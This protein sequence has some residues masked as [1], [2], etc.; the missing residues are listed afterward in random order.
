MHCV[1]A[2]LSTGGVQVVAESTLLQDKAIARAVSSILARSESQQDITVLVRTYVDCGVLPELLNQNAQILH[3]R[4]GT[5]K[6]HVFLVLGDA[7]DREPASTH[8]YVDLRLL[9]S[10][11]LLT[12]SDQ[13]LSTRCIVVFRDFLNTIQNRLLDMATDPD[14]DYP[15]NAIEKVDELS[16]AINEATVAVSARQVSTETTST[17]RDGLS[18]GVKMSTTGM[19][20]QLA[21]D[22]RQDNTSRRAQ[23]YEE[24]IHQTV[25]FASVA[26]RLDD[27]LTALGIDHFYLLVDEWASLPRDIQ[28]YVAEFLRRTVLPSARM[29]LKI[30]ALEYRSRFSIALANNNLVGF[31][32]G[33]DIAAN[34]NLDDYFVHDRTPSRVEGTFQELLYKHLVAALPDHYL[35]VTYKI[36]DSAKLRT[37][38]FTEPQTFV[39]VVRAGEGVVRDFLGIFCKAFSSALREGS[40]KI[41]MT[42]V[43]HAALEWYLSDK[44]TSLSKSHQ[45]VLRRIVSDVIGARKARS[46]L[47]EDQY[48]TDPMIQQLF[49]YRVLHLM[50]RGYSD[51]ER[52]GVRYDIYTLDYGTYVD[53]KHTTSEPQLEL[54]E[55][56]SVTE[57]FV[58][59][60]DDKRSIRRIVLGPEI[61]KVDED[62]ALT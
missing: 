52:P 55:M 31:E 32:L 57:D 19:A 62:D 33:S 4:R 38:L 59:P 34:T 2:H 26:G 45:V 9:G 54:L 37:R 1:R 24:A 11:Q 49:D 28:P 27:A 53:L 56:E 23:T 40:N 25:V 30:A 12:D 60:F 6:S 44:A 35:E 7:V 15:G 17:S 39:E 41:T 43:E 22:S 14:Q 18:A 47:V 46:F 61:L 51:K 50:T 3:G 21:A 5:G 36:N 13:P 48:R 29:V 8:L 10:A 58:V 42:T 20:A 16:T